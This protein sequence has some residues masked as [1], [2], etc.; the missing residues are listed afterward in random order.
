MGRSRKFHLG[1][2]EHSHQRISQR[3]VQTTHEKQLDPRGPF[4]SGGV[5]VGV[6]VFL[7]KPISTC[8]FAGGG[9][10]GVGGQD[11]L[12]DPPMVRVLFGLPLGLLCIP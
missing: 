4:A 2:P 10:A 11:P 9:Q 8:D 5:S 1:G 12:L 6:L 7:R 3:A